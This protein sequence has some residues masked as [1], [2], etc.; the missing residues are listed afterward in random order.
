MLFDHCAECRRCCNVELGYPPLE[1][2]LTKA[3]TRR[4]GRM[5]IVS[6]C[7]SLGPNGCELGE[8][9]PF[10]CKLYP[11]SYD[12]TGRRFYYDNE[13]PLMPEYVRQLGDGKSEARAHVSAMFALIKELEVTEANFLKRN[14]AV[15]VDYF[16]LKELPFSDFGPVNNE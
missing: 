8:A 11:L 1:I 16:D 3:E 5:C 13:C 9:K 2:T 10:S 4:H 15:D 7:E 12:P 6:D 14:F